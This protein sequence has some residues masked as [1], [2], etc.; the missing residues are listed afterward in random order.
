M[1][2]ELSPRQ[3]LDRFEP[4]WAAN[5][6]AVNLVGEFEVP[7]EQAALILR[8]VALMA[9]KPNRRAALSNYPACVAVSLATFAGA[10]Y[11]GGALWESLFAH[12]QVQDTPEERTTIGTAFLRALVKLDLPTVAEGMH[13]LAPITFHAVIPDYCL[14]DVLAL[15]GE[16]LRHNRSLDGHSFLAWADGHPS[17]LACLD[18]PAARFL[19]QG[20]EYAADLVDRLLDLLAGLGDGNRDIDELVRISGAP[21][22]M[23][24]KAVALAETGELE[25]E[26]SS[27]SGGRAARSGSVEGPN[28]LL[29][30]D[31][32][33][34]YLRLPQW[35]ALSDDPVRWR[36]MLDGVPTESHPG[37]SG[38]HEEV[39]I[40][41]P[42]RTLSAD[43]GGETQVF[44]LDVVRA[45]FPLLAF[46]RMG[47]FL[48]GSNPLRDDDVWL[49]YP[50]DKGSPEADEE[51]LAPALRLLGPVGWNGWALDLVC[52]KTQ[53][54]VGWGDQTRLVHHRG[55]PQLEMVEP[56]LGLRTRSGQHLLPRRPWVS[57]PRLANA[58]DWRV[59]VRD[60]LTGDVLADDVW[61]NEARSADADIDSWIDVFDGWL[62]AVVGEFDIL[63]RGPLGTRANWR[64]AVAEG[65]EQRTTVHCRTF[66]AGGLTP[67]TVDWGSTT[68]LAVDPPSHDFGAA[69]RTRTLTVAMGARS[70]DVECEPNHLEVCRVSSGEASEWSSAPLTLPSDG[71]LDLGVLE[72]RMAV[73]QALPPLRLV[74]ESGLSQ[75]LPATGGAGARQRFDL[76]RIAD[77]LRAEKVGSLQW[78]IGENETT[79]LATFRPDRLCAGA[80]VEGEGLVLRDFAGVSGVA[81]GV[82][83][84]LAPWRPPVVLPVS[85]EGRSLLTDDLAVAGPLAVHVR[86][87]DPWVPAPWPRWP[88]KAYWLH[89]DG[90]PEPISDA[91]GAAVH[92]LA[93]ISAVPEEPASYPYLWVAWERAN[94]LVA[95]GAARK[96]R[97]DIPNCLARR[98]GMAIEALIFTDVPREA[99]LVMGMGAGLLMRRSALAESSLGALWRRFPALASTADV[100][101]SVLPWDE[102]VAVC[103]DLVESVAEGANGWFPHVGRF[104]HAAFL[105]AK[106]PREL[107]AVWRAAQI[108]PAGLLDVDTRAAAG[109]ALFQ[110]RQNSALHSM[111]RDGQ[112]VAHAADAIL[113]DA[114]HEPLA[115][116]V[117]SRIP[118]KTSWAWEVSPQLS[119]AFAAMARLAARGDERAAQLSTRFVGEWQHLARVSPDIVEIDIVLA[120][121]LA[122]AATDPH[123]R[124]ADPMEGAL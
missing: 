102:L 41:R 46:D 124:E 21:V 66:V 50:E 107:E 80:A 72:V 87:E 24:R 32:S 16:R 96:L 71:N 57:L 28:L 91:E 92:Y 54:K 44:D 62:G 108:V 47:R 111:T 19:R 56:V 106:T 84:V 86:L 49:L 22:R 23:V 103:G 48:P 20:G 2:E 55:R 70:L 95:N 33:S 110:N 37:A 117:R 12:V 93:G 14:G 1:V 17:R 112:A 43:M 101:T 81:A 38:S 51:P 78:P 94:E 89:Q 100:A 39:V 58:T 36:V 104:D 79:T 69:D 25:F 8:A 18:K 113:R 52:L 29:D 42:V 9:R 115:A 83:Q 3:A 116:W 120:E 6:G 73:G 122:R 90:W 123:H 15:L 119:A 59:E 74:C 75:A 26:R 98:P 30:V 114:G 63:V 10:H 35:D 76:A 105:N 60:A 40:P 85:A 31:R 64:V 82:Y 68:G 109:M 97:D 61:T 118:V 121:M 67:V 27:R 34:I 99:A 77:T 88:Q 53:G 11:S 65:L 5:L 13:Y 7:T 45:D 4:Q